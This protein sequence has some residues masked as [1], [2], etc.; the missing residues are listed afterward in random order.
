MQRVGRI[1]AHRQALGASTSFSARKVSRLRH[2][3]SKALSNIVSEGTW[4]FIC[5]SDDRTGKE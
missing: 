4:G 1:R 3:V 2:V 5:H